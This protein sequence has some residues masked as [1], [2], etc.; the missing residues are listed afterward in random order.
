MNIDQGHTYFRF[1]LENHTTNV[2]DTSPL[3]FHD[4]AKSNECH[5]FF[6]GSMLRS[7]HIP[8]TRC[9]VGDYDVNDVLLIK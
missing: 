6:N 1:N 4:L 8:A 7:F 9:S 3:P 2:F 5:R